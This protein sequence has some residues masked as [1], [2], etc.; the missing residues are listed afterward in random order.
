M[1][2]PFDVKQT[3]FNASVKYFGPQTSA[4]V[5]LREKSV[6]LTCMQTN[7]TVL[8]ANPDKHVAQHV[9]GQTEVLLGMQKLIIIIIMKM[10][11]ILTSPL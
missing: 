5:F 9:K 6:C 4:K 11:I 10:M 7:G 8:R 2:T 1:S 3:L